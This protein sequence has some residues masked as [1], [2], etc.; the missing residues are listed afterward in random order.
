MESYTIPA[1]STATVLDNSTGNQGTGRTLGFL[2]I[3]ASDLGKTANGLSGGNAQ[4]VTPYRVI[5][6]ITVLAKDRRSGEVA[7]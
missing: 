4:C 1:S 6:R 3:F 5:E 7:A 2:K